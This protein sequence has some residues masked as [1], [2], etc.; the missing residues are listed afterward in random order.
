[1]RARD[2][3]LN[4]KKLPDKPPAKAKHAIRAVQFIKALYAIERRIKIR[5]PDERRAVRQVESL[6]IL[7]QLKTW[8]QKL[9]PRV[10]PSG[11]L[12]Q[13]LGHL[14]N[15]WP[16]LVRYCDDGRFAIDNNPAERALRPFC[17]KG[18]LCTSLSSI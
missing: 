11:K 10:N 12:G 4:P 9:H 1:M 14:L 16:G 13:T 6:P 17:V 7:E 3:G 8:A 5:P 2:A 18:S 15:H